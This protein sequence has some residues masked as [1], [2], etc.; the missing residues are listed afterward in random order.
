MWQTISMAMK[1][2]YVPSHLRTALSGIAG[3]TS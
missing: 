3:S 2:E 1:S